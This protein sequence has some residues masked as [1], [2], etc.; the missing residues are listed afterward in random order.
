MDNKL[1]VILNKGNT[2]TPID[3]LDSI[4]F[5]SLSEQERERLNQM[6]PRY[7]VAEPTTR[8]TAM[9]IDKLMPLLDT[10]Q[11]ELPRFTDQTSSSVQPR[12]AD[13]LHHDRV[14]LSQS[15]SARFVRT[16]MPQIVLL[17]G[18]F[19][20]GSL[21]A[22]IISVMFMRIFEQFELL[23][24]SNPI[25]MMA[26]LLSLVAIIYACR[27]YGTSM[28]ELERS[29]PLS[30]AKW[31]TSKI[32]VVLCYYI[33]LFVLA[34]F[35]FTWHNDRAIVPFTI[36]WLVPLCLYSSVTLALLLRL[37]NVTTAFTMTGLWLAQIIGSEK[38]GPLFLL[39]DSEYTYW[40]FS[41][42]IGALVSLLALAY[43]LFHL[44]KKDTWS[45]Q[46]H[47][48]KNILPSGGKS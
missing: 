1:K 36:S 40:A 2:M 14:A 4:E 32:T 30:P 34:S 31:I 27:S 9:L 24:S 28:F 43:I 21:L 12:F 29:F 47:N 26:P 46:N 13:Q 16:V 7:T 33:A 3:E 17:S 48:L 23:T 38:L 6:L 35:I 20:A 19:W 15:L 25:I 41:K 8:Q 18:W 10:D 37:G 44:R 45:V 22:V 42:I 11:A 5:E 39:G